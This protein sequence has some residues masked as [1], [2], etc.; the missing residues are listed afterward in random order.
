MEIYYSEP[1]IV[2]KEYTAL[3]NNRFDGKVEFKDVS[4]QYSDGKLP[5][6][7]HISF[8]VEPGQTIAIMGETGCGLL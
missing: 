4:F 1:E 8:T 6:L 5:V 3:M 2:D 7:K